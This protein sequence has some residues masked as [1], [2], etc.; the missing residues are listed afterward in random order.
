MYGPGSDSPR[1]LHRFIDQARRGRTIVTHRYTNGPPAL[2]LLPIDDLVSAFVATLKTGYA[3][4]LN[5]GTGTLVS[6]FEIAE[7]LKALLGSTSCIEEM[8]LDTGVASIAMD[9]SCAQAELKWRPTVD[10]RS[11]LGNLVAGMNL[12][13]IQ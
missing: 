8:H 10:F 7:M 4:T 6:T 12:D 9:S 13:R 3:G 2:D 5:L 11:G 1:F